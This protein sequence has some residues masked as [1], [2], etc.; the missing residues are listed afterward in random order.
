MSPADL[1]AKNLSDMAQTNSNQKN[2]FLFE[3]ITTEIIIITTINIF[4]GNLMQCG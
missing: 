4:S 3:I 2:L 1:R